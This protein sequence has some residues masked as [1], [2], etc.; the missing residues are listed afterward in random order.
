MKKK[1]SGS[2]KNEQKFLLKNLCQFKKKKFT[3]SEALFNLEN[4][5]LQNGNFLKPKT[6]E[7]GRTS[8]H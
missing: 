2:K 8:H 7:N 6:G 1:N 3:R 5:A 4:L